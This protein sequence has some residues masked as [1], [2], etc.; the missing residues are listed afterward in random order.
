MKCSLCDHDNPDHST[1]LRG[2]RQAP[3]ALP[4]CPLPAGDLGGSDA[5]SAAPGDRL[6]LLLMA[7]GAM[8]YLLLRDDG[9]YDDDVISLGED[10][11]EA[12]G[13]RPRPAARA[14]WRRRTASPDKLPA[15]LAGTVIEADRRSIKIRAEHDDRVY[16]VAVGFRTKYS[17]RRRAAVGDRVAV[18][19]HFRRGHLIG[20]QISYR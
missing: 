20:D 6:R 12:A 14:R 10:G 1:V 2:L 18:D 15:V 17:P 4:G 3:G 9:S 16:I 7:V 11:Q 13:R 19:Y 5:T 8:G